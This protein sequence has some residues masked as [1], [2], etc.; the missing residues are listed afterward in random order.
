MLLVIF[1][2]IL[3]SMLLKQLETTSSGSKTVSWIII[4]VMAA[5]M[6]AD[7]AL[8]SY[9]SISSKYWNFDFALTMITARAFSLT[10]DILWLISVIISAA[11]SLSNVSALRSRR[12]PG[13]VS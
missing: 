13:G 2:Y 6:I 7:L 3:N 9:V 11:F 4:G 12:L 10:V 8:S 1:V 5:V